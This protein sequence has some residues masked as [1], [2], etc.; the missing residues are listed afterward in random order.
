MKPYAILPFI[1]QTLAWPIAHAIF[2]ISGSFTVHGREHLKNLKGPVI[3]VANHVNDL[4]PVLTRAML[5]MFAALFWVA[6]YRKYYD[7]LPDDERWRGWQSFLYGDWFFRAWG[8]HPAKEGTGDYKTALAPIIRIIE[9]G[10]SVVIFPQGGKEKKYG[11]DAPA[12]GGA[13]FLAEHT[14]VPMVPVSI[15]GTLGVNARELFFGGRNYT[16]TIGAPIPVERGAGANDP[17]F[18]K[19]TMRGVV[20]S[21]HASL[22][23]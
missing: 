17:D 7:A 2:R 11:K 4:D 22:K 23:T 12:H 15:S 14:N 13:A 18:Y 19:N 21:I 6:R 8:A 16:L 20:A 10:Y 9:D 1:L 5:P 3:F